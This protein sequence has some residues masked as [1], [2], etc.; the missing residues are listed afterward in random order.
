MIN[1]IWTHERLKY[2]SEC[3]HGGVSRAEFT[4][5]FQSRYGVVLTKGQISGVISRNFQGNSFGMNDRKPPRGGPRYRQ[6][7]PPPVLRVPV[8]KHAPV[9][10]GP[11]RD[12]PEGN[13]CRYIHG[14]PGSAWQCCGEKVFDGPYCPYHT[15]ITRS[16][17]L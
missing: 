10:I 12:F 7:L 13:G 8:P 1:S 17:V 9:P 3:L 11:V 5:L 15:G 6:P 16:G 2:F 14:D 4:R